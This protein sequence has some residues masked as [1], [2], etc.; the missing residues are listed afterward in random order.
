MAFDP[1]KYLAQEVADFDPDEYL[2]VKKPKRQFAE[3]AGGAAFGRPNVRGQVNIQAEPRPLESFGAGVTKSMFI[4]PVLGTAQL[5]SGGN[6]GNA[7]I[8]RYK[9][10]FAP[11]QEANPGSALTGQVFG[12][13]APAAKVGSAIGQIPSFANRVQQTV[14]QLPSKI[15][16]LMSR[17]GQGAGYGAVSSV[18]TP[19]TE[20]TSASETM[21]NRLANILRDSTIGAALPAAFSAT[22]QVASLAPKAGAELLGLTTGTSGDVI[23]EAYKAGKTGSQEFLEN[24]RGEVPVTNL[25]ESAQSALSTMKQA[26]QS[27][28][29]K[30]FESTKKNQ[31]FL[32]FKPIESKFNEFKKKYDYQGVGGVTVSS[33]GEKTREEIDNIGKLINEWK[34]KPEVHTAQGL[35]TLKRRIDDLWSADMPNQAK[36]ALTQTRNVVKNTIVK[37][38]PNYAKTMKDYEKSIELEREIEKALSLGDNASIDTALRKLQSLGRNNVNT[39]Y[40]YRQQLA[41]IMKNETGVDLMPALSGQSLSTIPPRGINRLAT[42]TSVGATLVDPTFLLSLPPQSPRLM[43]ELLY[44]MGQGSNA[45]PKAN[46]SDRQKQLS[47]L[48]MQQLILKNQED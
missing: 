12:A 32:D 48:L 8:D 6:V 26:R 27:A 44:K 34:R 37:Q 13:V 36:T 30:G 38:D 43:G 29:E 5:V 11:Y 25:F 33:I 40:G 3:N 46:M 35:D 31:V 20:G 42:A 23:K 10:Q 15:Q 19:D 9:E 1:D 47:N 41:D 18:F 21:Q 39:N 2:G 14:R 22:K 4:D 7:A 17:I 24:M 28:F 16:P 45:I